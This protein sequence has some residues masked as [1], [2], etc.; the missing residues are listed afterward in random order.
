MVEGKG[1]LHHYERAL[2][3]F[4]CPECNS[5]WMGT[6]FPSCC[7]LCKQKDPKEA[8]RLHYETRERLLRERPNY[9]EWVKAKAE[10]GADT[11][12]KKHGVRRP[13]QNPKVKK[14]VAETMLERYGATR[15]S[16]TE[17]G[18]AHI[19]KVM[20]TWCQEN[21]DKLEARTAAANLPEVKKHRGEKFSKTWKS[22]TKEEIKVISSKRKQTCLQTFGCENP[23]QSPIIQKKSKATLYNNYG[24]DGLGHPSITKKKRE[25][26]LEKTKGKYSHSA[27]D[28]S[29]QQ[30]KKDNYLLKT[31]GKYEHP[32]QDPKIKAKALRSSF[33]TKEV[34][35]EGKK[36]EVQGNG[37]AYVVEWLVKKFG[38]RNIFT[39][40]DPEFQVDARW[41]PDFYVKNKGYVECKSVWTL[42]GPKGYLKKN[43]EKATSIPNLRWV[44][45]GKRG[46]IIVLPRYWYTWSKK[47]LLSYLEH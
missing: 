41:T 10:K 5:C 44:V 21:P 23:N 20:T 25:T 4:F 36:F 13:L 24:L 29:V 7:W 46:R 39:Q 14:Q 16:A 6:D 32:H 38:P 45:V 2:A 33:K 30:R 34:L 18:R 22:K 11:Y 27:Q 26:Y 37:E 9:E 3:N 31:G 47:K 28:P 17:E 1:L 19:S 15:Y 43:R 42:L 8:K 12:E 35:I 40:F